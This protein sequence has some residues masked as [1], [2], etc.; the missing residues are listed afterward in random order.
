MGTY[1]IEM[2][3]ITPLHLFGIKWFCIEIP[4]P[5]TITIIKNIRTFEIKTKFHRPVRLKLPQ[6]HS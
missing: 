4:F 2:S 1:I 6:I 5:R 3:L